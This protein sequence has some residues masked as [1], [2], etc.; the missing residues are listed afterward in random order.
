MPALFYKEKGTGFP[1]FFIH[2]FCETHEVWKELTDRLSTKFRTISVDLPGFGKSNA[3]PPQYSIE[4]AAES[5]LGLIRK[6]LR[7]DACVILGHS[8]GGYVSLAMVEK[9]PTLFRGMGLI[10]STA[11][12]DSDE[13]KL[14]RNKVI[15]FVNRHGV[16]P[17]IQS[18]IPPLFTNPVNPHIPT[19]VALASKT[20]LSTLISYTE[21]MRDRPERI[22]VIE[23]FQK[24]V[25]FIAGKSDSVIP[26][27]AVQEQASITEKHT[28]TIMEG[29]AHMG[30]LEAP[31]EMAIAINDFMA[32]IT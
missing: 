1:L 7:T 20:S 15:E 28:L 24:P 18:F 3:I 8:M 13:R 12:A 17:F 29:V 11:Y 19:T 6:K 14:S 27:K 4:A 30:M 31:D 23:A 32:E 10:H 2:G 16:E 22:H 9:D 5:V 21:A 25:L 26:V